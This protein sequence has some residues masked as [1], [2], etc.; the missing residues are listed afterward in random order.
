VK[1]RYRWLVSPAPAIRAGEEG[2]AQNLCIVHRVFVH[3]R[4]KASC[5]NRNSRVQGGGQGIP[6]TVP[7]EEDGIG[8][9]RHTDR[10]KRGEGRECRKLS[11][12]LSSRGMGER[13][14]E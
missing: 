11:L 7:R 1:R 3:G 14:V 9:D 8:W 10:S 2:K 4:L 5:P 6:I 12:P 13:R